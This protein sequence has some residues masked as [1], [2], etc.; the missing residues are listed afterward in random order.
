MDNYPASFNVDDSYGG[1]FAA[2][3]GKE[4]AILQYKKALSLKENEGPR[5]KIES[6]GSRKIIRGDYELHLKNR[7]GVWDAVYNSLNL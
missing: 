6:T 7:L 3:G 2:M 1:Y 4:M 5:K